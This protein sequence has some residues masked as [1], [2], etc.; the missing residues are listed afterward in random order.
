MV[1]VEK[2]MTKMGLDIRKA[3]HDTRTRL[4]VKTILSVLLL[5]VILNSVFLNGLS[6]YKRYQDFHFQNDFSSQDSVSVSETSVSQTFTA[7]GN[8]LDNLSVYLSRETAQNIHVALLDETGKVLQEVEFQT[9]EYSPNAWNTIGL[10]CDGLKRGRTYTL[11]LT[12]SDGLSSL[13]INPEDS[14]GILESCYGPS[15]TITGAL[16][17]GLQFTETYFTAGSISELLV[18]VGFLLIL[19]AALSY[20]IFNIEI[21]L[22]EFRSAE[23]KAGL[24]YAVF[25]SAILAMEFQPMNSDRNQMTEFSRVIGI[26]M[27]EGVDVSKR[28]SNFNRWF[29]LFGVSFIGFYLLFNSL[30]RKSK[31]KEAEKVQCFLDHFI[32]LA[33]CGL[34]IKCINYFDKTAEATSIFSLS[35]YVM[36]MVVGMGAAYM[37]FHLD[38]HISAEGFGQLC[39][40]GAALSYPLMVLLAREW[41]EGRVLLGV[42]AVLAAAILLLIRIGGAARFNV[43]AG[44]AGWTTGA[45]VLSFAPL[46]TSF[47]IESVHVL[48]QWE[49]FVSHPA[50]HYTAV[51]LLGILICAL[52]VALA[53]KKKIQL[54]HWKSIG[55]PVFIFG[56]ACLSCQIPITSTYSPDIFEGANSGILI[57]DFLNFGAIPNVEHYGGHMMTEVWEGILYGIVNR[58]FSGAFV[59]PYAT[60]LNPFLCVLFYYLVKWIWNADMAFFVVVLFPFYDYWKYY[61]LGMLVC[62]AAMAYIRKPSYLRAALVWGAFIW[63]ALYRLDL[64]FAYGFAL[65]VA[66][67][68]YCVA[69]RNK[70]MIRQLVVTLMGW[71]AVGGCLW[72]G[73]CLAKQINPITRL[74]E[75]LMVNLSN[76]NWA[77][78]GIGDTSI[79]AF[80]W[81]YVIIP[82]LVIIALIYVTFSSRLRE[83]IGKEKWI[84]LMMLGWSYF[85]N[86]SRGLVR[87]SLA[88]RT[89]EI[90]IWCGYLFLA[91]VLR[92]YKENPKW[93]VPSL[94]VLILCNTLLLNSGNYNRSTILDDAATVPATIVE[95]W[96]P[97]RF[98]SENDSTY[99]EQVKDKREVIQ[100]VQLQEDLQQ[101]ADK[102]E[103]VDT[104]LEEDETFADFINKTLLYCIFD[105][106][107]PTYI[108]QSPL[109]LSGEFMQEEF[110]EEIKG[111]PLILMPTEVDERFSLELDGVANSYRYYKVAEYVY[112][113]YQP[114]YQYGT[115]YSVWCLP[116]KYAEYKDKLDKLFVSTE[117]IRSITKAENLVLMDLSLSEENGSLVV[118][119]QNTDPQIQE[120]QNL[121]DL[122]PF[123]GGQMGLKVT[124]ETNVPGIMQVFY[125]TEA[126]EDYT[127]EKSIMVEISDT[128]VATF[129][130]PVMENTRIRLDFPNRARVKVS[131]F[132]ACTGKFISCEYGG[133]GQAQYP[134]EKA[135]HN[136]MLAQLP[137]IWAEEDTQNSI[138]N[139]VQ[140]QLER[141]NNVFLFDPDAVNRENGNYL[142]ISAT[143]T[144]NDT[145]GLYQADDESI[146]G[147]IVFGRYADDRFE[148]LYR[149]T[150]QFEEGHHDYMIR[151]STD[152][153]WYLGEVNAVQIQTGEPLSDVSLCLLDG[154]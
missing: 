56:I 67:T 5:F 87:H 86:F 75:F 138:E 50:K 104:L 89:T 24:P 142:K 90:V 139:S 72:C 2:E 18:K 77:L 66:L 40:I 116:E 153:F 127:E 140:Q 20:T 100:R 97:G 7:G 99:W 143:Y 13:M 146:D 30:H 108:S 16:V 59:S 68:I 136:Y 114:L 88:E 128:G 84:L 105:R 36:L 126:G 49:V 152:Y 148:P 52:A 37:V 85:G 21:L 42:M 34:L 134:A 83:R 33:D 29:L 151:C 119:C 19:W 118:T 44:N 147:T 61:G 124:Y 109:Q 98:D 103:L 94:L 22:K 11:S 106:R 117:Y 41:E 102:F 135:D 110:I 81:S 46:L 14:S 137:R 149:Y 48:N 154:D 35:E 113:N 115:D 74:R 63:C 17:I 70:E 47:Y 58:D 55:F 73:L 28:I 125:T 54:P 60:L 93:F 38:R 80:G 25:F 144:G 1:K 96:R 6:P 10:S 53:C 3:V 120:L 31:S 130:I 101:Y 23:K 107:C 62:L 121:V 141:R 15:G 45:M 32:I 78:A 64:G 112:Q 145:D 51:C 91:L 95:S 132:V 111:T 57:S 131:S 82:F 39:F 8:L 122:S 12:G 129:E 71:G 150:L 9:S 65:V 123:I 69:T 76:Q 4:V 43:L 92:Y 133:T 27:M 26:G 79:T